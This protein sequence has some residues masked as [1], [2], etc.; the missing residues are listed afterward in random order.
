MQNTWNEIKQQA[1][2]V[3][4][5]VLSQKRGW[6]KDRGALLFLAIV[7]FSI[8]LCARFSLTVHIFNSIVQ[9]FSHSF[10]CLRF[11]RKE[12]EKV[13]EEMN[14]W[15]KNVYSRKKNENRMWVKTQLLQETFPL[16]VLF[17]VFFSAAT[18]LLWFGGLY[19]FSVPFSLSVQV[20]CVSTWFWRTMFL[21]ACKNMV[22]QNQVGT[23]ENWTDSKK[24]TENLY[25]P[26][27]HRKKVAVLLCCSPSFFPV[28]WVSTGTLSARC[29]FLVGSSARLVLPA[30]R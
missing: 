16:C 4:K 9:F 8:T 14:Y 3:S 20:N 23:R 2:N 7:V 1:R 18:F 5:L 22:C 10:A 30:P 15:I 29:F 26:P 25:K 17:C 6:R 28:G 24:R 11:L 27:N 21:L 19:K 12:A 13:T